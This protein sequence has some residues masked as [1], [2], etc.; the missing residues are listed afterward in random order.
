[1]AVNALVSPNLDYGNG[2]LLGVSK[3]LVVV[4]QNSAMRLIERPNR[5]D[6]ISH[7]RKNLHWLPIPARR[8]FKTMVWKALND[9]APDYIKQLLVIKEPNN[10]NLRSNNQL[11]L[12]TQVGLGTNHDNRAFSLAIPK[13][14]NYFPEQL[15]NSKSLLSFKSNLKTHLFRKFYL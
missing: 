10:I 8:Q 1:M 15:K 11:L 13:L 9:Q 12:E 2:L 4:A 5:Y 7:Y 3:K 6:N 14:W